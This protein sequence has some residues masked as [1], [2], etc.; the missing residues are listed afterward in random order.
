MD[1]KYNDSFYDRLFSDL[2]KVKNNK[3]DDIIDDDM[4]EI[5][6]KKKEQTIPWVEKYRPKKLNDVVEQIEIIKL[7][8]KTLETGDFLHYLFYGPPGTGK[9]STVLALVHQL[10]GPHKVSERVLELNASNERGIDSVR[11]RIIKFAKLSVGTSDPKYKCPNF[12]II[13]LDEVDAMTSDAQ[14]AL[15]KVMEETSE[16]TRFVFI[17]NY[18]TKIIDPIKSRCMQI[19]FKPINTDA[20]NVK[21]SSI[22]QKEEV[23]I[24]NKCIETIVDI[25]EGDL[26]KAIMILQNAKYLVKYKKHVLPKDII[27]MSGNIYEKDFSNFWN[28]CITF[29]IIKLKQLVNK[30][31]FNGYPVKNMLY[32]I[33][34]T[35]L[36]SDIN[37][38]K[39]SLILLEIANIDKK[40]SENCDEYL[41]LLHIVVYINKIVNE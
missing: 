16:I 22:A 17:C 27:K 24:S 29:S 20:I 25:S 35:V 18:I 1:D 39:K 8:N 10:Y 36:S 19:F 37:D 5:I 30:I 9:T 11:N 6:I 21:L 34:K 15:R 7:L 4:P 40:L 12:K 23:N 28:N 3:F 26:R 38:K 41:Q 13:I 14:S 32:F 2:E 31:I 33:Q